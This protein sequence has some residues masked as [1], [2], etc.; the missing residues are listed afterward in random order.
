M[1]ISVITVDPRLHRQQL[2][3]VRVTAKRGFA[4]VIAT[5]FCNAEVSVAEGAYQLPD[6]VFD[7]KRAIQTGMPT[8]QN[9]A[10]CSM[11]ATRVT[12]FNTVP[13]T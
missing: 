7:S 9:Q 10:V 13:N 2:C 8:F 1:I 12:L 5:T 4:S 6:H 3:A 11:C